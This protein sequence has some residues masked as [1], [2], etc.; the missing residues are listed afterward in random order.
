M[1]SLWKWIYRRLLQQENQHPSN[2]ELGKILHQTEDT[3][4]ER[5]N[6]SISAVHT[7][8]LGTD[9]DLEKAAV[10]DFAIWAIGRSVA[11]DSC[12]SLVLGKYVQENCNIAYDSVFPTL[13]EASCGTQLIDLAKCNA[14]TGCWSYRMPAGI[15]SLFKSGYHQPKDSNGVYYPEL[16]FAVMYSG[17]HHTSWATFLN[18]CHV[19]LE[20]VRLT[21]YF[22]IVTTDGAFYEYINEYSEPKHIRGID[23]RMAVLFQL[24]RE[25]G[26]LDMPHTADAYAQ[27]RSQQCPGSSSSK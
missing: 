12:S 15:T 6:R 18:S 13:P 2:K 26:K 25:R 24:A 19:E 11:A 4:R 27:Q 14:Y 17:R 21:P 23:Y 3:D 5:F 22:D 16:R 9:S 7:L 10:Y 20:V 8:L 1:R